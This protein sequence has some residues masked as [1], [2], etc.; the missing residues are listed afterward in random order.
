[1]CVVVFPQQGGPFIYFCLKIKS[2][3]GEYVVGAAC[4]TGEESN[5]GYEG[6]SG[7]ERA[8]NWQL[9]RETFHRELAAILC[10]CKCV[11]VRGRESEGEKEKRRGIQGD[12]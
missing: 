11:C 9:D 5:R 8:K 6:G 3:L 2:D 7:N 12:S 4:V 1:M 10:V